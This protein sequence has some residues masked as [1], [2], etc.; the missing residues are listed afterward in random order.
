[1]GVRNWFNGRHQNRILGGRDSFPRA[2][3][4]C[5]GRAL[6]GE[7]YIEQ[8]SAIRC[9]VKF[10]ESIRVRKLLTVFATFVT[11]C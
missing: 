3:L 5:S 6:N 1:M 7:R 10:F 11:A 2:R 8:A 4:V 9:P